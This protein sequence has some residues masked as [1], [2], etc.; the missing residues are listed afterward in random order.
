M[1]T[2][3]VVGSVA[4]WLPILLRVL[5]AWLLAPSAL[6]KFLNYTDFVGYFAGLGIPAPGVMV[7]V[8]AGFEAVATLALLLGFAGWLACTPVVTIM[9]VAMLTAGVAPSNVIVLV[10]ALG[11]ILLGTE[12]SLWF[13]EKRPLR[14]GR[15][16]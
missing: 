13:P 7:A 2:D 6:S 11:I 1:K 15:E 16:N 3:G 5:L 4:W 10:G 9:A 8:V 14:S 12:L